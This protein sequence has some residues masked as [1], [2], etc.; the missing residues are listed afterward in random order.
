MIY[1]LKPYCIKP[2]HIRFNLKTQYPEVILS[3]LDKELANKIKVQ[4]LENQFEAFKYNKL[5][6]EISD[7]I[8]I[9][10]SDPGTCNTVIVKDLK[11]IMWEYQ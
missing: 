10:E 3:T 6:Q 9:C 5:Q 7:Y 8:T 2:D 1:Y 11:N 4:I